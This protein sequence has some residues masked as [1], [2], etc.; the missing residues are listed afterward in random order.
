MTPI[1]AYFVNWG[2]EAKKHKSKRIDKVFDKNTVPV[3][4]D[5]FRKGNIT[6]KRIKSL[7]HT[8]IGRVLVCHLFIETYMDKFIAINLYEFN[9]GKADLAFSQKIALVSP[10]PMFREFF[11]YDGIIAINKIRN[12]L[13]H[14]FLSE[15][16]KDDIKTI[17]GCI[18][19]YNEKTERKLKDI[20]SLETH[21][22]VAV[23]EYFTS[24]FC[25][26]MGGACAS[27]VTY[28]NR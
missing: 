10:H 6:W 18:K 15:L 7:P 11:F 3:F 12:K 21:T 27:T 25:A 24:I 20:P 4:G 8:I 5:D 28:R 9:P 13:A 14:N 17:I 1:G 2:M 22:E 26:F 19:S 23:I 16:N